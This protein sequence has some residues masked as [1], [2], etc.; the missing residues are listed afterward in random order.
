MYTLILPTGLTHTPMD[1]V[2]FFLFPEGVCSVS[3]QEPTQMLLTRHG[4]YNKYELQKC[5]VPIR[6]W[7]YIEVYVNMLKSH[8]R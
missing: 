4:L 1:F 3:S 7:T 5:S 6:I 2:A 8:Y